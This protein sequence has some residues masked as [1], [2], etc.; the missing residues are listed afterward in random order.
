MKQV[1]QKLHTQR[2]ASLLV[3]LVFFLVCAMVAAVILGSATTNTLKIQQRKEE[4]QVYNSVSSAAK[5]LRD[6]MNTIS[7]EGSET[8]VHYGCND[9]APDQYHVLI[10]MSPEQEVDAAAA[11]PVVAKQSDETVENDVLIDLLRQ[12]VQKVYQSKLEMASNEKV[13]FDGWSE[14][15]VIDDG[16]CQ[17]TVQ[18]S[19][20]SD[21]TVTFQLAPSDPQQQDFYNMILTCEGKSEVEVHSDAPTC[22]HTV[23]LQD[24]FSGEET[25]TQSDFTGTR[26]TNV[27][28]ISWENGVIYKGGSSN[29]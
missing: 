27:T 17:V 25:A 26:R 28:V 15:F 18:V 9:Y 1:I 24:L 22:T 12:G 2:G 23:T 13:A 10:G 8:A 21:Y 16:L 7:M 11:T 6:T 3:A 5:F 14:S 29:G 20:K 19:I 4:K